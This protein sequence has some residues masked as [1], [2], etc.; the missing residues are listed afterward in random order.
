MFIYNKRNHSSHAHIERWSLDGHFLQTVV[1]SKITDPTS[2]V[3]D[4]IIDR[5]YWSDSIYK[6]IHTARLDGTDRKSIV[7]GLNFTISSIAIFQNRIFFTI[8][9]QIFSKDRFKTDGIPYLTNHDSGHVHKLI[10]NSTAMQPSFINPCHNSS[11]AYACLP[12]HDATSSCACPPHS[13]LQEDEVTC[14]GK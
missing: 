3:V 10:F 4:S 8:S 7:S 13:T 11:C 6:H 9:H 14:S 12:S 2:I 5:I 1:S